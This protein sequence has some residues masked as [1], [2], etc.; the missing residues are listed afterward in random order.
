[1]S[2]IV[3]LDDALAWAD[4]NTDPGAI[5]RMRSRAVVKLLADAVRHVAADREK[6]QADLAE[7][8]KHLDSAKQ[9][10]QD[11]IDAK[12]YRHI[13]DE[14]LIHEDWLRRN[15]RPFQGEEDYKAAVNEAVDKSIS[16]RG[17]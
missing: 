12:R 13:V 6:W 4:K 9:N 14:A 5:S 11:A 17:F 16:G 1:M 3:T 8:R 7:Y 2:D 15:L 10:A